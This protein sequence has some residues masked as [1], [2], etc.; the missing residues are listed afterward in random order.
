M[1]HYNKVSATGLTG[2]ISI[3]NL[4]PF[5]LLSIFSD[6]AKVLQEGNVSKPKENT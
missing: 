4:L 3:I 1:A 6:H 5:K 2:N